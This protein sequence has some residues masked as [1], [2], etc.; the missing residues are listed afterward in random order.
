VND[1]IS[2]LALP[3]GAGRVVT[4]IA[5]ERDHVDMVTAW[6]EGTPEGEAW[7]QGG[8]PDRLSAHVDGL[9][10]H[11]ARS[12]VVVLGGEPLGYVE[13][14]LLG[15]TP[16]RVAL[17]EA[18]IEVDADDMEWSSHLGPAGATT[19]ATRPLV[20]RGLLASAFLVSGVERVF[21]VLTPDERSRLATCQ[22]IGMTQVA[23]LDVDGEERVV[24]CGD[25]QSFVTAWP[26][27]MA[28]VELSSAR[29]SRQ[30]S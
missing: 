15:D 10:I 29:L 3:A 4:G 27:D 7:Q 6:G 28:S 30:P 5:A 1:V 2:W 19:E 8:G 13:T 14:S 21:A 26:G 18:E 25:R 20:A 23:D 17:A 12:W 9:G 11:G 22:S 16:L 24:L